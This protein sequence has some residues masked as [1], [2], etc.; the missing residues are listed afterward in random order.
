MLIVVPRREHDKNLLVAERGHPIVACALNMLAQ[1]GFEQTTIEQPCHGLRIK[2][3]CHI[4]M[5]S[6]RTK[7]HATKMSPGLTW[8]LVQPCPDS[9]WPTQ[10][11]WKS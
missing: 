10:T 5:A 3:A 9:F 4:P 2:T 11:I 7:R 6:A 1:H 8:Q